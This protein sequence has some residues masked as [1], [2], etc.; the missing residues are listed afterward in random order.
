MSW[1]TVIIS[2]HAKLDLQAGFLV[3]RTNEGLQ[4]VILDEIDLL[5]IENS[6]VSVTVNLLAELS[7]RKAKV[8]ICD[9]TRNPVGELMPYYGCHD[10]S[11]RLREQLSWT[12]TAKAKIWREIVRDKIK[13][14]AA[15]LAARGS[16]VGAE[17]L[18]D[19]EQDVKPD[20]SSNRE[21]AS[22]RLYFIALFGESFSR[23]RKAEVNSALDYGYM[24]ML[25]AFN[26]AVV[27]RGYLTQLGLFHANVFNPYNLSCDLMEPFRPLVDHRVLELAGEGDMKFG[28]EQKRSLVQLLHDEIKING[29]K[30]TVINSISIFIGSVV[31]A[32]AKENPEL[33]KFPCYEC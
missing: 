7:A 18:L 23:N 16:S 13:H 19:W 2:R 28:S 3:V 29:M 30:Q 22:A 15:V 20:D 10:S 5:L 27:S 12:E 6:A 4:K 25:A 32:L 8:I 11:R 24:V 1:R 33:I 31:E 14:Q 26:R 9:K 17:Q 21:G